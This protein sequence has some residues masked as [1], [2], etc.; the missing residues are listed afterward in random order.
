MPVNHRGAP[1][2]RSPPDTRLEITIYLSIYLFW[3]VPASPGFISP[4]CLTIPLS[5]LSWFVP[6]PC[7]LLFLISF[8]FLGFVWFCFRTFT[9]TF[10]AFSR[11]FCSKQ[12][13]ISTFFRKKR[14]HISLLSHGL[15]CCLIFEFLDFGSAFFH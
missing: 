13:T 4:S 14:S 8:W 12:L 9:F 1:M 2:S 5:G 7:F 3:S 10:R 11:R 6:L 15:P